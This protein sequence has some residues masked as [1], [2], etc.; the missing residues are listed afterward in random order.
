[1]RV[2]Q[3]S[4]GQ[5]AKVFDIYVAI[6]GEQS[7]ALLEQLH[8]EYGDWDDAEANGDVNG[9]G[10]VNVADISAIITVMA[11]GGDEVAADV[12]GDGS[13][14]VADISAVIDIMAGK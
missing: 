7:K 10:A 11:E 4:G 9:D 8:Q 12:N 5:G 13:V 3:N 1:M 6:E 2:A 14:N